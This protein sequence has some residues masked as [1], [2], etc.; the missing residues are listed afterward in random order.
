MTGKTTDL[1]AEFDQFNVDRTKMRCATCKLPDD[2]K[3]WVN[4]KLADG[5]VSAAAISQFLATKGY[6]I[7]QTAV[8][9]H[10]TNHVS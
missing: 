6:T 5:T 2:L 8:V 4:T 10:R 1:D 7:S 9:N 3:G